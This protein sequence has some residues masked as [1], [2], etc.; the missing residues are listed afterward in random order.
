[1]YEA[2]Y[3][4][5][6][7][8]IDARRGDEYKEAFQ[9][10]VKI[11]NSD[12]RKKIITILGDTFDEATKVKTK[13]GDLFKE[14]CSILLMCKT[15]IVF[16][17]GNHDFNIHKPNEGNL[18]SNC[19]LDKMS[20]EWDGKIVYPFKVF[21]ESGIYPMGNI[22][23]HVYS[24]TDNILHLPKKESKN[25]K[26][27][28]LHE[29]LNGT[30][31]QNRHPVKNQN[32]DLKLADLKDFDMVHMGDN[33]QHQIITIAENKY[34]SYPGSFIQQNLGECLDHGFN[35]WDVKTLKC[36]FR[37]IP[38]DYGFLPFYARKN[39]II[40]P[41]MD[42]L[43]NIKYVNKMTFRH[44][45]CTDEWIMSKQDEIRKKY[46]IDFAKV[47]N[48]S[49]IT[50]LLDR[51]M[52]NVD[53]E[54]IRNNVSFSNTMEGQQKLITDMAKQS[55]LGE[56]M[57]RKLID[58]H[59]SNR[60]TIELYGGHYWRLISLRWND[61]LCYGENNFVDFTLF[62]G[63]TTL[64]GKNAT[65]KS[66]I[67]DILL[68][69]LFDDEIRG[70]KKQELVR[71]G[72]KLCKIEIVVDV[73]EGKWNRYA[74]RN[75]IHSKGD[76]PRITITKYDEFGNDTGETKEI[77]EI[78]EK[79]KTRSN[80]G[81]D[82]IK[83]SQEELLRLFG[84]V[85]L[86]VNVT[87]SPQ[88]FLSFIERN[89]IAQYS[90]MEIL[91]GLKGVEHVN[92]EAKKQ[93]GY[94]RTR[95]DAIRIPEAPFKLTEEYLLKKDASLEEELKS[96][97]NLIEQSNQEL[98]K[99]HDNNTKLTD[100][101]LQ[102]RQKYD[103]ALNKMMEDSKQY[104]FGNEKLQKNVAEANGL[105]ILFQEKLRRFDRIE[106]KIKFYD[107]NC[108]SCK[109]NKMIV[110]NYSRLD[111]IK[112]KLL[113]LNESNSEI[114]I[115]NDQINQ[116]ILK[117][118]KYVEIDQQKLD[119]LLITNY[120]LES[121][122]KYLEENEKQILS[123]II[124]KEIANCNSTLETYQENVRILILEIEQ[125][126][127]KLKSMK[128][129]KDAKIQELESIKKDRNMLND[130]LIKLETQVN[131]FDP[132]E[133]KN[134]TEAINHIR[135]EYPVTFNVDHCEDCRKNKDVFDRKFSLQD[136]EMNLQKAVSN[137]RHI[138]SLIIEKDNISKKL[139]EYDSIAK[140]IQSKI[141]DLIVQVQILEM[142]L[143]T[144]D[145]KLIEYNGQIEFLRQ[146]IAKLK[147]DEQKIDQM[148]LEI[149]EKKNVITE[150][151]SVI[152]LIGQLKVKLISFNM[153]IDLLFKAK[154]QIISDQILGDEIKSIE[155]NKCQFS[156][157][158]ISCEDNRN[159]DS[160]EYRGK[161]E[162]NIKNMRFNISRLNEER[163]TMNLNF[164]QLFE[165]KIQ[166][167]SVYDKA[168]EKYAVIEKDTKPYQKKLLDQKSEI[169]KKI[170]QLITKKDSIKTELI[171]NSG[172]IE[173]FNNH[174]KQVI[175]YEEEIKQLDNQMNLLGHYVKLTDKKDG[176][177]KLVSSHFIQLINKTMNGLLAEITN[178]KIEIEC[179]TKESKKTKKIKNALVVSMTN[180]EGQKTNVRLA[181]GFQKFLIN[182]VFRL[183]LFKV[184][185]T[186]PRFLIVDEGFGSLDNE[187]H[188]MIN[189]LFRIAKKHCE[190][191]LIIS[192]INKIEEVSNN[193]LI[194]EVKDNISRLNNCPDAIASKGFTE[195]K[196]LHQ[197][198]K[199]VNPTEE[200][201]EKNENASNKTN[202][203]EKN[204]DPKGKKDIIDVASAIKD[205]CMKVEYKEVESY[206]Y[207]NGG[208][209]FLLYNEP[210][211][212]KNK[213]KTNPRFKCLLCEI[214]V[215]NTDTMISKHI[216]GMKHKQK[217]STK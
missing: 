117:I 67:I 69:V 180:S 83:Q 48:E 169:D 152:Q 213:N 188:E 36:E 37:I 156:P 183:S 103:I 134:I 105:N 96:L 90:I 133:I 128:K 209:Y 89:T 38:N 63:I 158:C 168:K 204:S 27:L 157:N 64:I 77:K 71:Y 200:S 62:K 127:L 160:N 179:I 153:D 65:G 137:K 3:H 187:N 6:D 104:D 47:L 114:I 175:K 57:I 195:L 86:F 174:R 196:R 94:L 53:D 56:E 206:S 141:N 125:N 142:N 84:P 126:R 10:F 123:S 197:T 81:D 99:I 54:T 30:V 198:T 85:E 32:I 136:L 119:Q 20:V 186:L 159:M 76:H 40:E 13:D 34:A 176:F 15:E 171:K 150:L 130:H 165:N 52:Q 111:E 49:K 59:M 207:P 161:L 92:K 8:H 18:L 106:K 182:I 140:S 72:E 24:P 50:N 7:I 98:D 60:S 199:I 147:I 214:E 149:H 208:K 79:K 1:M 135:K 163:E 87:T 2:I 45:D 109:N 95:K 215:A 75:L 21:T 43:P 58:L 173:T 61:V 66:T 138:D 164:K 28:L 139:L 193:K 190:F 42:I 172:M 108:E 17:L 39:R 29:S 19:N 44:D 216:N 116:D 170:Q 74:I 129:D 202:S 41:L 144:D 68:R 82:K 189:Q 88:N 70:S 91:S 97:L 205:R 73:Y 151:N 181:S 33:H 115:S 132:N 154:K 166:S 110:D 51:N 78:K 194:I 23:F 112:S 12:N 5:A 122:I 177:P 155:S 120:Q 148:R 4:I 107:F 22:D 118:K 93:L 185:P 146:K 16:I 162:Q 35:I 25:I 201:G 124:E 211:P 145:K 143:I 101:L 100:L 210:S 14:I 113:Q 26:V 9:K 178:F 55:G 212:G 203:E 192:H 184:S 131:C 11:V 191:I 217:L 80:K 121:K 46:K 167:S 102:D 31:F